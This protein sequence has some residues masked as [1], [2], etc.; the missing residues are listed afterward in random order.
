MDKLTKEYIEKMEELLNIYRSLMEKCETHIISSGEHNHLLHVEEIE[1]EIASLKAEVEEEK[2]KKAKKKK[3][4]KD[5]ITD[6]DIEAWAEKEFGDSMI[7]PEQAAI[8]GAKAA[9]NG[10]IKHIEN[11]NTNS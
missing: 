9:L 1:S 5:T 3:P 2:N 6:S 8:A 10:E 7:I 11:G 4:T